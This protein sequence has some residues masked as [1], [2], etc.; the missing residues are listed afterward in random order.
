[1]KMSDVTAVLDEFVLPYK[2]TPYGVELEGESPP[3]RFRCGSGIACNDRWTLVEVAGGIA[4]APACRTKSELR[5]T[6]REFLA[7]DRPPGAR[8]AR[9][10]HNRFG[11]SYVW[12]C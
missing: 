12:V 6:L 5:K 1:M 9:L 2:T 3:L 4:R 8:Y 7:G 11:D 10:N